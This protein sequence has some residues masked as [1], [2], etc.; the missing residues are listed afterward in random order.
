MAQN[1]TWKRRLLP[2]AA[3]LVAVLVVGGAALATIP[4]SD[5]AIRG[6]YAKR[7]GALRVLD[8]STAQCK[9]NEN[10]LTWNQ[11]GPKGES[12][13]QGLNGGA[14]ATGPAGPKG[15]DGVA[16][17]EGPQGDRGAPGDPGEPGAEGPRGLTGATGAAGSTGPAGPPGTAG[18]PGP[19]GATGPQGP[20]GGLLGYEL[21]TANFEVANLGWAE[22]NAV[23]SAGKSPLGGGFWVTSE[24]VDVVKSQPAAG[25]WH[26]LT[27]NGDLFSKAFVTVYAIC[28]NV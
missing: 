15:E 10:T 2:L 27:H 18:L 8:A 26:V 19:Q 28:A 14:G 11:A 1:H 9:G 3:G 6:C 17:A 24:N 13:P 4:G 21:K 23:C 22:G 20:A 7:D 25:G 5:G 16:G 12:G